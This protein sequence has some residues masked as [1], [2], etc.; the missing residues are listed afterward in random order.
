MSLDHVQG[1]GAPHRTENHGAHRVAGSP[2]PLM[3]A[4]DQ[5]AH[6]AAGRHAGPMPGRG[7]AALS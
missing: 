6:H 4:T 7:W 1:T 5:T 2:G 3:R